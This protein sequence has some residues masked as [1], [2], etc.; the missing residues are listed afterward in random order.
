MNGH[1]KHS[2]ARIL[3]HL[4]R[5]DFLERTRRYSFL[6]TLELT[7]FTAYLYIPPSSANYLTLGLGNYRGV[8]NS[9]WKGRFGH[10]VLEDN[11]IRCSLSSKTEETG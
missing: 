7:V 2:H 11:K 8:Y 4:M 5:A 1:A 6:I 9:A 3:Y 10:P